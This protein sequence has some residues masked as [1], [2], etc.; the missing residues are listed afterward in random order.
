MAQLFANDKE[1]YDLIMA[2]SR[3]MSSGVLVELLQ[4]RRIFV[5]MDGRSKLAD[6]L[7]T[8]PHDHHDVA[9]LVSKGEVARRAERTTSVRIPGALT[10]QDLRSA[11]SQYI[12]DVAGGEELSVQSA[13][14]DRLLVS[15][16]YD[17]VEYSRTSLIQ[18]QRRSS[19]FEF[20]IEDEF[21]TVRFPSNE[22]AREIVDSVT[23][24]LSTIK[25]H[26]YSHEQITVSHIGDPAGRS[27]FFLSL[28]NR[29]EGFRLLHV[30]DV[31]VGRFSEVDDVSGA[32]DDAEVE[33][34]IGGRSEQLISYIR[35]VSIRGANLVLTPEFKRLMDGGFFITA[36]TWEAERAAEPRD[37]VRFD[38]SFEDGVAGTGLRYA[39]RHKGRRE[40][41]NLSSTFHPVPEMQRSGLYRAIEIAARFVLQE[42]DTERSRSP[43]DDL[44]KGGA[45]DGGDDK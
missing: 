34:V 14:E 22:K 6:M 13:V 26:T 5:G 10:L 41:G 35:S 45:A 23:S 32:D 29:V 27:R 39:L 43:S 28:M 16:E 7:A 38:V 21:V 17:E 18:K 4:D 30:T 31:R 37:L 1:I 12:K 36:L 33:A 3:R 19:D 25:N 40:N 9:G 8:L 44:G 2:S 11:L 15:V 24:K 42:I 20:V